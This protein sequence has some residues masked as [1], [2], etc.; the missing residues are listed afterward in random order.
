MDNF[1]HSL[2]GWALGQTGLK[3][4]TR[5][6]L[7]ALV[8][9]ANMP[10]IDVFFGW[11]PWVP[12]ATHRGFTHG[13]LGGIV[14][15]P[16][17]VAGLLW[18]LDQEQCR[19]GAVFRSGLSM[20]L[21]WL[22]GL[23]YLGA[24]T[25]PLLDLQTTY[26][27]QLLSPFSTSWFHTETLFIVDAVIWTVLPFAI[28]LS[29]RRERQGIAWRRP[30]ILGL[31]AVCAYIGLNGI[32]SLAAR[33]ALT[34][35]LRQRPEIAYARQ[36]PVLFWKRSLVWRQDGMIGQASYDPMRST[37]ALFDI[38]PSVRDAMNDPLARQAIART[39]TLQPFLRWSTMPM[40]II[41]RHRC[42][43]TISFADARFMTPVA[44]GGPLQRVRPFGQ[45][46]VI[47][48]LR[49]SGCP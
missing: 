23:S 33:H 40:A 11:A 18:L 46:P 7:A 2:V 12:L 39:P 1:T 31:V 15:L 4:R 14:I 6:G 24:I 29:R 41:E 49:G 48:P 8:L 44:S 36:E 34:V 38:Q 20:N 27:V 17:L 37:G 35:Q 21:P 47:L 3:T 28:W 10:D 9:G 30:A 45:P 5:K 26:A 13:L 42:T 43:A 22:I 32:I 16:A 25:H 19:R